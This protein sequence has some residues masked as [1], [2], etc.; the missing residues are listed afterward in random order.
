VHDAELPPDSEGQGYAQHERDEAG[1]ADAGAADGAD[2]DRLVD[3]S[4]CPVALAV[5]VVVAPAD[6]QLPGQQGRGDEQAAG[7]RLARGGSQR[8]TYG[9]DDER[10]AGMRG[11]DQAAGGVQAGTPGRPSW[12]S[13]DSSR[14]VAVRSWTTSPTMPSEC[15]RTKVTPLGA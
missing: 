1:A 9:S 3:P 11:L 4:T 5:D 6:R 14:W 7:G 13:A 2:R 8:R 10:R 12:T 15:T